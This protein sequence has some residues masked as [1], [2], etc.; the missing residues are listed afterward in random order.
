[1]AAK[2]KKSNKVDAARKKA[3]KGRASEKDQSILF[4]NVIDSIFDES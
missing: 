1:V 2:N 4:D 3:S